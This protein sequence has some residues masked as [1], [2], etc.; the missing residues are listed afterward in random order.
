MSK[1]HHFAGGIH[2]QYN[3]ERTQGKPIER[4]PMPRQLILYTGQHLGAPAVPVVAAKEAV[5]KG[6]LIAKAEHYVSAPVHAPTSGVIQEIRAC[7]TPVGNKG[8]AIVLEPDG[9]D[10]WAEGLPAANESQ[11]RNMTGD[12]LIDLIKDA[13]VVGLGGAV[14]PTHV[15][16]KPPENTKI[17]TVLINGAECEPY[18]TADDAMMRERPADI[19]TG[20]EII[21][22]ILRP[23][24]IVVGIEDNKPEA[25]AAMEKAVAHISD[26]RVAALPS[27]YPQG[28]EKNLIKAICDIWVEPG[29]LPLSAG[30]V[31]QNT[32]TCASICD[33]VVRKIPLIEKVIT[34]SG[35]AVKDAKNV[36][37]PLGTTWRDLLD[38]C[39]G[40]S[41]DLSR[42]VMGGPMMGVAQNSLD[43]AVVKATNGLLGFAAKDVK[44]CE[45]GP[46]L[47]CGGCVSICPMGLA[48]YQFPTFYQFKQWEQAK[49]AGVMDCVLCG[50]CSYF[51]PSGRQVL[52]AIK[53]LK[54][55]VTELEAR[56]KLLKETA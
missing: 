54:M 30:I 27:I 56:K 46:C 28:A 52:T 32:T 44:P 34:V 16:L 3:K 21:Q 35:S 11:W 49:E 23:K 47:R 24:N 37:A 7:T 53:M 51:C 4:I 1:V 2:L 8:S 43:A 19:A 6:Q 5:K 12:Q 13:G 18:L 17:N 41:E 22:K 48:P 55:K 9:N 15:K 14:F 38:F 36:R 42:L 29:K 20:I 31:V 25:I 33:A 40:V 39:G 26:C 10:T 50:T 45:E